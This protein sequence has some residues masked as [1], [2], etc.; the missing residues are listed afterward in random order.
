MAIAIIRSDIII[1]VPFL[2]QNPN[3]ILICTPLNIDIFKH[4]RARQPHILKLYCDPESLIQSKSRTERQG[5]PDIKLL[6]EETEYFID[7]AFGQ[8]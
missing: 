6:R 2:I 5:L 8:N 4:L 7:N 1:T 3:T